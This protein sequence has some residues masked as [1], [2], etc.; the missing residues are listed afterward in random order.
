[1]TR[2]GAVLQVVTRTTVE[3]SRRARKGRNHEA[4][5]RKNLRRATEIIKAIHAMRLVH[6]AGHHHTRKLVEKATR[7][8]VAN[9]PIKTEL[10]VMLPHI[11]TVRIIY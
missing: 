7:N 6:A 9:L 4:L 1:M 10:C 2:D 8:P 11:A 3:L 5:R